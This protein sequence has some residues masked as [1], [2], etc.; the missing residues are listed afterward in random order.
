MPDHSCLI[1]M[2]IVN[3]GCIGPEG[4]DIELSDIIALVGPNNTGK[5]TVLRAYEAA[6][7]NQMLSKDEICINSGGQSTSVE[8]WVHLPEAVTQNYIAEK[9]IETQDD[10]RLVRSKWEWTP[11]DYKPVR[12]TWDPEIEDYALE[13]KAAGFDTKFST[14]LPQPLRIEAL[15]GPETEHKTLLRL[16]LEPIEKELKTLIEDK[17]SELNK[18]ILIVKDEAK[19]PVGLFKKE[20]ESIKKEINKSFTR[21]FPSSELLLSIDL[22]EIDIK[23]MDLL[24]KGSEIKIN[25]KGSQMGYMQQGTGAQRALFW[26]M[27]E[28]RS[29]LRKAAD[30]LKYIERR[31]KEIPKQIATLE[32]EKAGLSQQQAIDKRDVQIKELNEELDRLKA[33]EKDKAKQDSDPV[34]LPGYMLLID[35]PELAL[36][37][38]AV[39][40]AKTYLYELAGESGWQVMLSTHS[41]AFIDPL[42]DHTTIVRL[43]RTERHPTP[44]TYRSDAV[45]FTNNDRENLKLLLKFD[46]ALAEMFF[47]AYPIIIEGDTE[48]A[49]FGKIMEMNSGDYPV[50]SMPLLVR[51]RGKDAITLI[52]KI[53]TQFKVSFSVLHD[54]DAPR[55][56]T[57]ERA[58]PAWSA[59]TRIYACLTEARNQ[60]IRVVHRISI[61][62][63]ERQHNLPNVTKDKPYE[64]WKAVSSDREVAVSVKAVLDDLRSE[65]ARAQPFEGEFEEF[66]KQNVREWAAANVPDDP[67]FNFE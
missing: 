37:P 44:Q 48:F 53:L 59:N 46:Q 27:L 15:A 32:R 29:E 30:K 63:F 34:G 36:H 2:R 64:T 11:P 67:K 17:N 45:N 4:L 35:E 1:K 21:T 60:G 61:P 7:G 14:R 18:A 55:T 16:I 42:E 12:T 8:I 58:S 65:T 33:L 24:Q 5:T 56:E 10:L 51:A 41:P 26:S 25:E 66:L 6:V 62:E 43:T 28:V 47:G 9:W 23:P 19:K 13:E 57:G 40:A 54:S 22:A 38:N 31:K 20:I 50:E 3:F 49:A 52:V 39:R